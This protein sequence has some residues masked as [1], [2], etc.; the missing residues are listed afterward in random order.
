MKT[1]HPNSVL[2]IKNFPADLHRALRVEAASQ[3]FSLRALVVYVLGAW[4]GGSTAEPEQGRQ[5]EQKQGAV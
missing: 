5:A 3:G 1:P 4:M 2:H